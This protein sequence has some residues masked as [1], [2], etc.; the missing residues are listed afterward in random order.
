[1]PEE[2]II[3]HTFLVLKAGVKNRNHRILDLPSVKRFV[4]Q[5]NNKMF[6]V[7]T[8]DT[9]ENCKQSDSYPYFDGLSN[10]TGLTLKSSLDKTG[11]L[12]VVVGFVNQELLH[13]FLKGRAIEDFTVYPIYNASVRAQI[14]LK[15]ELL[16]FCIGLKSE[17]SY[18]NKNG[19][20]RIR[21]CKPFCSSH[22]NNL[23]D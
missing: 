23:F 22:W 18:Y 20:L 6:D 14:C 4:K 2:E 19:K 16:F 10:Q 1:M 7:Y 12:S 9:V 21:K 3:E 17:S 5:I 13:D 15:P 11:K 8:L